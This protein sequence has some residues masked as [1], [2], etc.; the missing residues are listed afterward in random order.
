MPELIEDGVTGFLVDSAE[1]AVAAIARVGD[2]DRARIR[3]S[4][5]D[6]F[7]TAHMA[8]AYLRLYERILAR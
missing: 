3:R 6:R 8:D 2:L 4:V 1:E 5:E 7:T